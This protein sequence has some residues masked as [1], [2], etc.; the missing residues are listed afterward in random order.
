MAESE[1]PKLDELEKGQWPSF[2]TEI[3]KAGKKKAA[4]KDLLRQLELS[5][6]DGITHWKHGGVV[7]VKGY[8][9]GVIGRH[10]DSPE[11]FP[12]VADFHTFRVNHPSGWFYTTKSLRKICDVWD[13]YGSG[14]TNMH[15]STG[16]I[17]LLG[18]RTP[19]LQ[20]CFD[21][22]TDE[23]GFDTGGSSS[24]LRTPSCCVGQ[25]RCEW[26]CIDTMDLCNDITHT[27]QDQLHRPMWPY[28]FK[29]KIA[30][31]PTDCVASIARSDLSIIGTWKDTLRIDQAAVKEYASK[32]MDIENTVVRKCPT[33]ALVYDAAAKKLTVI[34][35]DCVRCMHCLHYMPKAIRP[36]LDKGATLLIGGKAPVQQGARFGWVIVPFVK[37]EPPYT[38]LKELLPKI[39]DWW[40]ENARTRER[41]SELIQRLGMRA[42]LEAVGLPAVPQMVREPRA[43]AYVNW[44]TGMK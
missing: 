24:D 6:N 12:E 41:V 2:V 31:C 33:Q 19:V 16:D 25:A 13:K 35:E 3:K 32:G 29:I 7:G 39:W 21:A 11:K 36:G 8:G 43:N 30:G 10:S 18:A 22:L 26:A 5:Y 42:F 23:A 15:G 4:A 44:K 9:A 40:D 17:I 34:A 28:K 14:L 38:Y 37:M 1:T 27:Y 20:D